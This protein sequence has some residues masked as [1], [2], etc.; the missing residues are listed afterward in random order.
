MVDYIIFLLSYLGHWCKKEISPLR[1][2]GTRLGIVCLI[3]ENLL[4]FYEHVYFSNPHARFLEIKGKH[5]AFNIMLPRTNWYVI[6]WRRVVMTLT[7]SLWQLQSIFVGAIC[8]GLLNS[9]R[10]VKRGYW[11]C[12]C[13]IWHANLGR[14][15]QLDRQGLMPGSQRGGR[16]CNIRDLGFVSFVA[17]SSYWA[18]G[19]GLGLLLLINVLWPHQ[20][21]SG[22]P[23][24]VSYIDPQALQR[25]NNITAYIQTVYLQTTNAVRKGFIK[26]SRSNPYPAI[27]NY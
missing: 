6:K 11:C 21:S 26:R 10:C 8:S 27:Q 9:N 3:G 15:D 20:W 18:V 16:R 23:I 19:L 5:F 24:K 14:P 13:H 22:F 4:T 25:W 1:P 12:H 2:N 17:A 7:G